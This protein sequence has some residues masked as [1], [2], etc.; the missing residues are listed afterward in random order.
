M[1]AAAKSRKKAP[2]PQDVVVEVLSAPAYAQEPGYVGKAGMLMIS[3]KT[4]GLVPLGTDSRQ[5][6]RF[7]TTSRGE[8]VCHDIDTSSGYPE[9]QCPDSLY[10]CGTAEKPYCRHSA[11]LIKLRRSGVI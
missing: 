4:Y 2:A 5:G 6:F 7:Y 8:E 10:R 9:C 3:G 1:A 11:C